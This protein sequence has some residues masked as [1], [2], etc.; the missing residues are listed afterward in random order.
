MTRTATAGTGWTRAARLAAG[1]L[2]ALWEDLNPSAGSPLAPL[3][4]QRSSWLG[5]LPHLLVVVLAVVLGTVAGGQ[6]LDTA[7]VSAGLA[8]L[9]GLPGPGLVPADG[10]MVAVAGRGDAGQ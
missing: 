8:V 5:W 6:A 4:G 2:R 10:R 7:G 1:G 3:R 9:L